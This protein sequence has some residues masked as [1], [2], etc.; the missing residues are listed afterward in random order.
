[1][2][3]DAGIQRAIK[4]GKDTQLSD[5]KGK[6]TGRLL[7][8]IRSGHASWYAQQWLH[9]KK[10]LSKIG[11]YPGTPLSEARRLFHAEFTPAIERK[12][13]IRITK[14]NKA[15]S[16]EDLF[17]GYIAHLKQQGKRSSGDAEYNLMRLL[18]SLDKHQT[19][20]TFTAEDFTV[21][22]RPIYTRG[23]KSMADHMR[24]YISSAYNWAISSECDYRNEAPKRFYVKTNPVSLIPTEP[25]VVGNR[26][27]SV[28]ELREF[29][30]WLHIREPHNKKAQHAVSESNQRALRLL[31]ITG[32]RVEMICRVNTSMFD[33]TCLEWQ[34]TKNGLP[35]VLP[36]PEQAKRELV[37]P[38]KHGWYFPMLT[39]PHEHVKDGVLYSITRRFVDR[40]GVE[41]FA[42]RDLRRTW[43]TLAGKAGISKEYRDLIQHHA[44]TDVSARHYDRYEYLSEKQKGMKI[45]EQWFEDTII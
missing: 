20:N 9:G 27:L 45:W 2:L 10:R 4:A 16:L 25:K 1:M 24:G 30:R 18:K 6:G 14:V 8:I 33:G 21:V 3:T 11:T 35:H 43:K 37:R 31:I 17:N 7:L 34:T 5:G 23:S 36:V 22:L 29:W 42:P 19:A 44:L 41:P 26:W 40:S 15:G 13:D 39:T 28:D 38:N 12:K 32:Q